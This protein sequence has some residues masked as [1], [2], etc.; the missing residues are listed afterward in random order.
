M[1]NGVGRTTTTYLPLG[2]TRLNLPNNHIED[3]AANAI[4]HTIYAQC[5][6]DGDQQI[7]LDGI[8]D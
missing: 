6:I 8:V 3:M 5:N 7:L 4:A 2:Y 1:G